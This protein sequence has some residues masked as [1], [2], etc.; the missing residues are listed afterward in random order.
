VI[1]SSSAPLD[2]EEEA[3]LAEMPL[4]TSSTAIDRKSSTTALK[5]YIS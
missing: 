1:C 5:A 2:E 3:L 4:G